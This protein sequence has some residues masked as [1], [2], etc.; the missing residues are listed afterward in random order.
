MVG[1]PTKTL[2][3]SSYFISARTPLAVTLKLVIVNT[4]SWLLVLSI[5]SSLLSGEDGL[6][7]PSVILF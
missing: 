4:G 5:I 3:L 2:D 6:T 7:I 1:L